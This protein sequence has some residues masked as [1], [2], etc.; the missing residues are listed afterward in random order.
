M[1]VCFELTKNYYP[2]II[3]NFFIVFLIRR[4]YLMIIICVCVKKLCRNDLR[5]V[6]DENEDSFGEIDT[7]RSTSTTPY[8]TSTTST[9]T[10][11]PP[12]TTTSTRFSTTSLVTHR[13]TKRFYHAP[14]SKSSPSPIDENL[15]S[16]K[17]PKT[18]FSNSFSSNNN[19]N[20]L[21]GQTDK[22]SNVNVRNNNNNNNDKGVTLK[23]K[24]DIETTTTTTTTTSIP[25]LAS[26]RTIN[27][28]YYGFNRLPQ[29]STT[30]R[31]SNYFTTT[32]RTPYSFQFYTTSTTK[33]P[34][35]LSSTFASSTS[36]EEIHNDKNQKSPKNLSVETEKPRSSTYNPVFD[37][38]FKQIGRQ[39]TST[40]KRPKS[41]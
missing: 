4:N 28:F 1:N 17:T 13:S 2:K 12:S 8:T 38:Y 7:T 31:Q 15:P 25:T 41:I 30:K 29:Y 9:T 22:N 5:K 33:S 37:V 11:I 26:K 40:S 27:P 21:S 24:E 35:T 19:Q 3:T 20:N 18:Y 23:T 39:K 36:S 32:A 14:S 10:P 16:S 6:L 34:S